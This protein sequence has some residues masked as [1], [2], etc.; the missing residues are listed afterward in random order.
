MPARR[1]VDQLPT[2]PA[3]LPATAPNVIEPERLRR[4]PG[5]PATVDGVIDQVEQAG[6]DVLGDPRR[7]RAGT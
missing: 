3:G 5:R 7:D 4:S 6:L 1:P 2:G